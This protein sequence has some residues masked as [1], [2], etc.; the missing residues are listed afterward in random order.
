MA[1][2]TRKT[3]TRRKM[4]R[5]SLGRKR[6]RRESRRSTLSESELFAGIAEPAR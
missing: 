4:K 1:S 2:L 6:K 3:R 5:R